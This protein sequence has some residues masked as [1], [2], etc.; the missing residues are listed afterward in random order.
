M[1]ALGVDNR[2]ILKLV[3]RN[4][5]GNSRTAFRRKKDKI[6]WRTVVKTVMNILIP[7]RDGKLFEKKHS[8]IEG[9]HYKTLHVCQNTCCVEIHVS[10]RDTRVV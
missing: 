7:K 10:C 1:V 9:L 6:Q 5:V 4:V 3:Q 8:L 2:V